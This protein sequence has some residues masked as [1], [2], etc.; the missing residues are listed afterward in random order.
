M[1]IRTR[2]L[3]KASALGIT[4]LLVY[5]IITSVGGY[6]MVRGFL[7]SGIFDPEF[8]NNPDAAPPFDPATDDP[9]QAF[10]G[11]ATET[12]AIITACL[13]LGTCALW[14]GAGMGAGAA[15]TVLHNREERLETAPIKGGAAAGALAF[16]VGT[17]LGSLVSLI[18]I[19]PMFQRMSSI[20]STLAA[21]DPTMP[22]GLPAQMMTMWGLSFVVGTVCSTLFWAGL[23]AALGAIG[24]AIG[25]SFVRGETPAAGLV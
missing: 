22:P 4:L 1:S 12:F 3:L 8:I 23:G 9:F 13:G 7:D 5:Y 20:F 19:A 2:P 17:L 25:K 10:F 24:S 16:V 21:T 11:I 15:Y 18:V 6:F 14:L